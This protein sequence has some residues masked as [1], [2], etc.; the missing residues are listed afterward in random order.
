MDIEE[1]TIGVRAYNAL[2]NAGIDTVEDLCLF[3]GEQ[4]MHL[5]S[6]GRKSLEDVQCALAEHSLSLSTMDQPIRG[7]LF[8]FPA[9]AGGLTWALARPTATAKAWRDT[10]RASSLEFRNL[11]SYWPRV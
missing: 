9:Q 2:K 3:T 4:L 6:F 8:H 10:A 5:G 11:C 7:C 1:L